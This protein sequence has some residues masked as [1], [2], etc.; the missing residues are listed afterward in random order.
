MV[1]CVKIS[2]KTPNALVSIWL[3]FGDG[4][5]RHEKAPSWHAEPGTEVSSRGTS[6]QRVTTATG[7]P[8]L[9]L[10]DAAAPAAGGSRNG[11]HGTTQESTARG[12]E[13]GLPAIPKKSRLGE[14]RRTTNKKTKVGRD[15]EYV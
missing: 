15:V 2:K 3:F 5:P 7:R 9:N 14:T 1:M 12:R 13:R 10:M 6:Q 4:P 11:L 8:N